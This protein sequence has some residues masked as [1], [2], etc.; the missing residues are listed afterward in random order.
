MDDYPVHQIAEVIR[1]VGT[2]DRN[3]Y[4]RYY[5]NCA[6]RLDGEGPA[7]ADAPFLLIIGMG[8]YPNLGTADAFAVLR[9]GDD[10]LVVRASKALGEDRMDT[11]VGPLRIEV[12]E[13]LRRLRVVLE[14]S[15]DN[16][17][18]SFDLTFTADAPAHLETRHFDRSLGRVTFDTQRFVQTGTWSGSI[19][20]AQQ[21]VPVTDAG[22]A[23]NRDRSW[24]VRPVGEAEPPG[25]RAEPAETERACFFWIYAVLR[26]SEFVII[27]ILQE[28]ADGARIVEDAVRLWRAPGRAPEPLALPEHSLRFVPGGREVAGAELT[29]QRRDGAGGLGEPLRIE[30]TPSVAGYIGV[31][32]GYGLE[33]DWRHGMWQGPLA[34]QQLRR[35]VPE[36]AP[37][38]RML[39][40]V[41]NIAWCELTEGGRTESG[42]GLFECA[43][44]G[45][46][47]RYGFHGLGDVAE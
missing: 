9:R 3:F 13:G 26:F 7:G 12:I 1:H 33:Q 18:L 38:E 47:P 15:P 11:A 29:F 30:C 40:P 35:A 32:T 17:D 31:G 21:T 42:E 43:V 39:C 28:D 44:I 16:P 41:D 2:S 36:I 14:P 46:Y 22:W 37:W 25:R 20:V 45:A 34:V 10:H 6:P 27:T 23:G 19:T 4:D 24:G 8:Q 5:F